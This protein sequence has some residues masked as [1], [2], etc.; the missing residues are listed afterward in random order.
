MTDEQ[1]NQLDTIHQTTIKISRLAYKLETNQTGNTPLDRLGREIGELA[2]TIRTTINH[3][4][5]NEAP[6]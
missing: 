4:I 1:F 6:F 3:I 2:D 5:I